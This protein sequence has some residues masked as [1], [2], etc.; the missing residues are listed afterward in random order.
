VDLNLKKNYSIQF[1]EVI[2]CKQLS[3]DIWRLILAVVE[4]HTSRSAVTAAPEAQDRTSPTDGRGVL[5][6]KR[7]MGGW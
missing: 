7:I 4:A 3:V 2:S 1:V 6:N 5:W